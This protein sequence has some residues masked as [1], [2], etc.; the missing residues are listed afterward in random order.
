MAEN[1]SNLKN[2]SIGCMPLSTALLVAYKSE[3]ES[4]QPNPCHTIIGPPTRRT[5]QT[6]RKRNPT[7]RLKSS[8]NLKLS[9]EV[10]VGDDPQECGAPA[11]FGGRRPRWPT[12]RVPASG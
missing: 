1:G 7:F 5:R 6:I 3:Q 10:L 8:Q 2:T 9:D 4:S 12:G 11:A